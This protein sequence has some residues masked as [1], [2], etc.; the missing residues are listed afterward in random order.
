MKLST[1]LVQ[2]SATLTVQCSTTVQ[3]SDKIV[4]VPVSG[5]WRQLMCQASPSEPEPAPTLTT[6]TTL[7]LGVKVIAPMGPWCLV[8]PETLADILIK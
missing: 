4:L 1:S 5:P 8:E 3:R 7:P 2:R 6:V